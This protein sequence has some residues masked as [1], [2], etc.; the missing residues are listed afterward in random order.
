MLGLGEVLCLDAVSR[1][2]VF[3][4]IWPKLRRGYLLDA[5]EQ[6]DQPATPPKRL[7]GFVD[8]VVDAPPTRGPAAGLGADVRL[9]GP[10]VLGSGLELHGETIQ[11]SVYSTAEPADPVGGGRSS[12][13]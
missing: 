11:L 12:V 3:A 6:L 9:K 10:G 13:A 1:P 2:D 5:L 8:E 4:D 7:L